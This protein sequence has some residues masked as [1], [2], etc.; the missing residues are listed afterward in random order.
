MEQRVEQDNRVG[1]FRQHIIH[2]SWEI[3]E[4]K[5]I[6]GYSMFYDSGQSLW[7]FM[8][9]MKSLTAGFELATGYSVSLQPTRLLNA[10]G[11]ITVPLNRVFN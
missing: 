10:C 9:H 3:S 7:L 4:G 5:L 1:Y 6:A 2:L 11:R 8:I